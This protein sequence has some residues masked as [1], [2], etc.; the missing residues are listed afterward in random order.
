M[1]LTGLV[2]LGAV[3]AGA[4]LAAAELLAPLGVVLAA[5]PVVL[6]DGVADG[7]GD[8]LA[9]AA[10]PT[11]PPPKV[12][13]WPGLPWTMAD[14]GLP[15]APSSRV[16]TITQPMNAAAMNAAGPAHR[17]R[18]RHQPWPRLAAAVS[19]V[20]T[21]AWVTAAFS[22]GCS[23]RSRARMASARAAARAASRRRRSGC[24]GSRR[25]QS[26]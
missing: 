9:G 14:S 7:T 20:T 23:G 26:R 16:T 12:V 15:A 5:V 1:L 22:P 24:P 8:G 19:W 21:A 13:P 25:A 2:L 11:P 4:V 18:G 6:A 10:L 3:A 17:R